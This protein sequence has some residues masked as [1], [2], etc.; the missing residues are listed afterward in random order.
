MPATDMVEGLARGSRLRSQY[1]DVDGNWDFDVELRADRQI[2]SLR[3]KDEESL[4]RSP[5]SVGFA[6]NAPAGSDEA[7]AI[8]QF[9]LYGRPFAPGPEYVTLTEIQ[10]SAGLDQMFTTGA[11]SHLSV[12]PAEG[13][14]KQRYPARLHCVDAQGC[15]VALPVEWTEGSRGMLGGHCFRAAAC[16]EGRGCPGSSEVRV[17]G[18]DFEVEYAPALVGLGSVRAAGVEVH[19]EGYVEGVAEQPG[20]EFDH[21]HGVVEPMAV[22]LVRAPGVD[23]HGPPVGVRV[24]TAPGGGELT[25]MVPEIVPPAPYVSRNER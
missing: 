22:V 25:P 21:A 10:L 1:A 11:G 7:A 4:T 19:A 24:G 18:A 5:V 3:P 12:A 17:F 2:V 20:Q 23:G 16:G 9:A 13:S 6:L 8:Q 15:V 14:M